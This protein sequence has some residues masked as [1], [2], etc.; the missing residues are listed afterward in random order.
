MAPTTPKHPHIV[1]WALAAID[2][3]RAVET[4]LAKY[5][6]RSNGSL[7]RTKGRPWHGKFERR[8]VLRRRRA[9]RLAAKA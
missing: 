8:Q 5:P 4:E 9:E 7:I 3:T 1:D 6:R 2:D